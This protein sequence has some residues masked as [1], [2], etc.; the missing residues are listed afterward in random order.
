VGPESELGFLHLT[1]NVF[2]WTLDE[3]TVSLDRSDPAAGLPGSRV[4]KGGAFILREPPGLR[5]A[6]RFSCV[7]ESCL[8]CVGFRVAREAAPG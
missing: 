6:R 7:E 8:D 1:G 2:E 5:N 3:Y 4:V